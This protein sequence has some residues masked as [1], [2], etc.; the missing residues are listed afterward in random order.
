MSKWHYN[1]GHILS[2]Y[3][4][5]FTVYHYRYNIC[6]CMGHYVVLFTS[7]FY[8][9]LFIAYLPFGR[10]T[11]PSIFDLRK[12]N[13]KIHGGISLSM[14]RV[15]RSLLAPTT[16]PFL[17]VASCLCLYPAAGESPLKV[18]AP[19]GAIVM[20]SKMALARIECVCSLKHT[21]LSQ[22]RPAFATL[23]PFP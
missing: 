12:F 22:W 17:S 3:W 1:H 6:T 11:A 7:K 8:F 23:A 19:L 10:Q 5:F 16:R 15:R 14:V 2:H 21:L 20:T 9:S 13:L 4:P 18:G